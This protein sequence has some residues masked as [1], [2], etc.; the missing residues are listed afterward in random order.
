MRTIIFLLVFGMSALAAEPKSKAF[1][2][3]VMMYDGK[4]DSVHFPWVLN[5]GRP[6][7]VLHCAHLQIIRLDNG[8]GQNNEN[9]LFMYNCR[10]SVIGIDFANKALLA[11]I[12]MHKYDHTARGLEGG[13]PVSRYLVSITGKPVDYFEGLEAT[14]A[15]KGSSLQSLAEVMTTLSRTKE[16]L[17]QNRFIDGEIS[18]TPR[19]KP[20]YDPLYHGLESLPNRKLDFGGGGAHTYKLQ[21]TAAQNKQY[22]VPTEV[23]DALS[24]TMDILWEGYEDLKAGSG[25][26]VKAAFRER[27]AKNAETLSGELKTAVELMRKKNY[28]PLELLWFVNQMGDLIASIDRI[29]ESKEGGDPGYVELINKRGR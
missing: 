29:L 10:Y 21:G 17:G 26:E 19:G 6:T 18:L 27:I 25:D 1:V 20:K 9:Q 2:D 24:K 16:G 23:Y 15:G 28:H 4:V 11:F 5:V 7:S 22:P 3:K 12:D 8:Y 13:F 14:P